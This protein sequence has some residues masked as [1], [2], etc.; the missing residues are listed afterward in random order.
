MNRPK[1]SEEAAP[2]YH[3]LFDTESVNQPAATSS[4]THQYAAVPHNDLDENANAASCHDVESHPHE[5][6][7][8]LTQLDPTKPHFH[9][10]TCDRQ[11]ERRERLEKEDAGCRVVALVFIVLIISLALLGIVIIARTGK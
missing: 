4:R 10:E 2:A 5:S 6:S 7:H 8:P 11:L 1:A 9:C 3:E